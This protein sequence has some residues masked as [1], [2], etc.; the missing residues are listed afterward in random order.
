MNEEKKYFKI[1]EGT[2]KPILIGLCFILFGFAMFQLGINIGSSSGRFACNW[3]KNYQNNF[4][5][6]RTGFGPDFRD[7]SFE[8]SINGHGVFGEIIKID[9]N[10][11]VINDPKG[12]EKIINISKTTNIKVFDKD[13]SID[14]LKVGDRIMVIG[15][16]NEQGQIDAKLIRVFNKPVSIKYKPFKYE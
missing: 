1:S 5:G 9:K 13:S 4:G 3:A 6:P 2:L 10:D 14:K 8:D 16:P 12:I 7:K 11:I 15:D